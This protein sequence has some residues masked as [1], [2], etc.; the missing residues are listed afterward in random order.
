MS[1]RARILIIVLGV[2]LVAGAGAA[3]WFLTRRVAAGK[4]V[5][6]ARIG[7]IA[8]VYQPAYARFGGGRAGG[9]IETLDI[10]A[11]FPGFGPAGEAAT[12]LAQ[13][14]GRG[15]SALVFLTLARADRK[16]DPA[17]LVAQLYT[18]FLESD[19]AETESGLVKRR[20]QDDSPY[21]T[22]DLYFDPPDGR[23]F[24]ARCTRPTKPSDGLPETC[25]WTF[26]KGGLDISVR[27]ERPLL[28]HWEKLAQ[29]AQALVG[30]MLGE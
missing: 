29:G 26:R 1:R 5:V 16:L 28:A 2:A 13:A 11:A 14:D 12:P 30:S 8:L 6:A 15:K 27:F 25:L 24:A 23:A 4:S 19:V 7:D 18:R 22:E 21:R 10:A 3:G 20:F 17:D 9:R